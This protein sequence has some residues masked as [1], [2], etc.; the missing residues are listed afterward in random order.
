MNLRNF[1]PKIN[2]SKSHKTLVVNLFGG[3]GSGKST[4]ASHIFANLKWEDIECELVQEYAKDLVWEKRFKTFEDQVY[5][6][7]KQHHRVF[8]LLGQVDVVITDSPLLLTP[9]YDGEKRETLKKLSFEEFDKNHNFNIFLRRKKKY[10]PKGRN[11][12][13]EGAKE[14]DRQI[15]ALLEENNVPFIEMDGTNKSVDVIVKTI[16]DKLKA[17]NEGK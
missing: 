16:K 17:I 1:S 10:N 11:Q 6:F 2:M 5:M 3:P 4:S 12:D 15:K 7:G 13:E 9:I 8:R 14:K